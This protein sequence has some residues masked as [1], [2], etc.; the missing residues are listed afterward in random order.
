MEVIV[1]I[2]EVMELKAR[3]GE[4]VA[5]REGSLGALEELLAEQAVLLHPDHHLMMG[6]KVQ[7]VQEY[8]KVMAAQ[9]QAGQ[10]W[11]LKQVPN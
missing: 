2:T 4:V 9:A 6:L 1:T 5:S 7:V 11:S 3:V 10:S 8:R